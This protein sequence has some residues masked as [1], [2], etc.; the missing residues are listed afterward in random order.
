MRT[1]LHHTSLHRLRLRLRDETGIALVEFALVLPVL[2]L[3]LLGALDLGKAYN[4]WIDETHLA[5]EGA[6]FAAVNKNPDPNQPNLLAALR[7][8]ADTPELRDGNTASV[9]NPL[10]V[11]VYLPDGPAVGNRVR[12]EVTST[13]R[14]MSFITGKLGITQK[15]VRADSTMRLERMP[16][17]GDGDCEPA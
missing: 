13:Y 17:F 4:Y 10:R 11:C 12:V 5:H 16:S 8:Q 2:A 14:F 6:R 7:M 9:P 1:S 3:V 15:A